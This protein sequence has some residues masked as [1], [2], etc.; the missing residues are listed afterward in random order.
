MVHQKEKFLLINLIFVRIF[1]SSRNMGHYITWELGTW[2]QHAFYQKV[3]FYYLH[4]I[5]YT[6][7][8]KIIS[9]KLWPQWDCSVEVWMTEMQ[10]L[11]AFFCL[12]WHDILPLFYQVPCHFRAWEMDTMWILYPRS[13]KYI[14]ILKETILEERL[15]SKNLNLSESILFQ[16][17][18]DLH[19]YVKYIVQVIIN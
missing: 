11:H 15:R 6:P 5:F 1:N 12:M 14:Q 9:L 17:I 4:V 13:S 16:S 2:K 19:V 7:T 18:L 8:I 3:S 10:L